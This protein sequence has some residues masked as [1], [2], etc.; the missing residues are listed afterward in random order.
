MHHVVKVH[1]FSN[2]V[3]TL[4]VQQLRNFFRAKLGPIALGTRHRRQARGRKVKLPHRRS[5]CIVDHK[6]YT[7]D[8]QHIRDFVRVYK[9]A[10]RAA[11][12]S[13]LTKI[14]RCQHSAFHM[15]VNIDT[16]GRKVAV[17]AVIAL[18]AHLAGLF[19]F[20]T[21][22]HHYAIQHINLGRVNLPR[23]HID[24][25]DVLYRQVA[26]QLAHCCRDQFTAIQ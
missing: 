22:P 14:F 26:R 18:A 2:T 24:K 16:T 12:N 21:H 6:F 8:A 5:L 23:H 4:G 25:T 7:G 15:H 13:R 17:C 10:G 3:Y 19:A 1:H 11:Q 20:C 9:H